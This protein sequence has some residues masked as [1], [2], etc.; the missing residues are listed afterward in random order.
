MI[1]QHLGVD[2]IDR[3]PIGYVGDID[4]NAHEFIE[5]GAS[6]LKDVTDIFQRLPGLRFYSDR[7]FAVAFRDQ[8]KLPGD[9]D[10]TVS[11]NSLAV[12]PARP[13]R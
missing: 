6:R 7:N 12:V 13:R 9:E 2:P 4:G 1:A 5:P 11:H 8:W 10:K 3:R